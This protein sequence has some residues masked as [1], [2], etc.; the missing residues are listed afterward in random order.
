M[1]PESTVPDAIP[2][3]TP[4]KGEWF[5][6]KAQSK[7]AWW[8]LGLFSFLESSPLLLPP[9]DIFLAP[10]VFFDRRRALLLVL[11]TTVTSTLGG[12]AAYAAAALSFELLEPLI[13]STG[14]AEDIVA[15]G[16]QLNAYTFLATFIGALTP[17]PYTPI[18]FAAGFLKVNLF[19]FII[20]TL[21]GRAVRYAAVSFIVVIFG[22][23]IL[24]RLGKFATRITLIITVI[25]LLIIA[26]VA[27]ALS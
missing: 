3:A 10:M 17:I 26:L 12:I 18:A 11:Y 7:Y 5:R 27:Y 25:A 23:A 14:M 16:Q 4:T 2:P 21:L 8:W 9:T 20:A 24:P 13:V 1:P 19:S 6:R 22:M 15:A